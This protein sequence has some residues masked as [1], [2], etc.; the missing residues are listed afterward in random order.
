MALIYFT[1]IKDTVPTPQTLTDWQTPEIIE[2]ERKWNTKKRSHREVTIPIAKEGEGA[3]QGSL[4][5]Q[6]TSTTDFYLGVDCV[7]KC[8]CHSEILC[9]NN[10]LR[11]Q[12]QIR[13]MR[14]KDFSNTFGV[15]AISPLLQGA[16]VS[17]LHPP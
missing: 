13:D 5:H 10:I 12:Q 16:F 14:G 4:A 6:P 3:G 8:D 2:W 7:C 11:C 1:A 15:R 17:N 9:L